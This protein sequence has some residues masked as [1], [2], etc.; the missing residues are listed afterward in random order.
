MIFAR[1]EQITPK[2]TVNEPYTF[3]SE[4]GVYYYGGIAGKYCSNC[5]HQFVRSQE[6]P[7]M[8]SIKVDEEML[9]ED[10][11]KFVR[12]HITWN[13]PKGSDYKSP[14]YQIKT[15]KELVK[16]R[17]EIIDTIC[18]KIKYHNCNTCKRECEHRPSA[19]DDGRPNCFMWKGEEE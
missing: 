13:G 14:A 8:L 18:K 17:D 10:A 19:G 15:L 6:A 1:L 2:Y 11:V 7:R 5:G 16:T 4:C 9:N 12:D 3:C